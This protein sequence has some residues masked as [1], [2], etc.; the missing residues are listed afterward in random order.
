MC[1]RP[2]CDSL[3]G[4][5]SAAACLCV[6]RVENHHSYGRLFLFRGAS[7]AIGGLDTGS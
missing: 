6:R 3:G 4:T 5:A 2:S 7:V 1:Q